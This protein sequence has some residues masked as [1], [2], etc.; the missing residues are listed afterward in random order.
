MRTPEDVDLLINWLTDIYIN[1]AMYN[2]HYPTEFEVHLP[3]YSVKVFC[4]KLMSLRTNSTDYKL[5]EAFASALEVFTNYSGTIK[6]NNI[7]LIREN[8]SEYAWYYQACTELIMPV[9]STE[10]DMFETRPWDARKYSEWCHSKY[11]VHGRDP[12]WPVLEYGGKN[13]RYSSNIVFS[14]GLMDP[15]SCGGV[16]QN[17]SKNILVVNITDGAHHI[18]LRKADGADT[19]F[20]TEARKI[21]VRAIKHWLNME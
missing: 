20:V 11:G 4:D 5:V 14:N 12:N 6:C 16:M 13:L 21:H 18:D 2:Y 8:P 3:A 9:C 7:D 19:N 17:V 15:W 1:L 10:K